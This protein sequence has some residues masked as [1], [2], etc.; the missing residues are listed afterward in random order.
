MSGVYALAFNPVL[1]RLYTGDADLNTISYY[2]EGLTLEKTFDLTTLIHRNRDAIAPSHISIDRNNNL[3]IAMF[4]SHV[5]VKFDEELNYIELAYPED[6]SDED[7]LSESTFISPPIV[8]TDMNNDIWVCYSND[9]N[10]ML[11]KFNSSGKELFK[12]S[13]NPIDGLPS[14][15]VPVSLAIDATNG[16]W[17]AC[18]HEN[19]IRNYSSSG[20]LLTA[21]P[22]ISP[23]YIVIDRFN[24]VWVTHEYDL[25]SVYNTTSSLVSTWKFDFVNEKVIKNIRNTSDLTQ[26]PNQDELWGGLG[27]DVFDNMWIIDSVNNK[28]AKFDPQNPLS[29]QYFNV[30]PTVDVNRVLN[31]NGSEITVPSRNS[32][33][34]QAGGDWTG[35]R[36]Y[37]KYSGTY[38]AIN[39]S[40]TSAPF[41][42]QDL[43]KADQISKINE[44]F[45]F[46]EHYK[47]LALPEQ[48]KNNTNL[49]DNA[50]VGLVGDGD[51]SKESV[52]RIVYEKIA[53]FISAHGDIDTMDSDK[54]ISIAESMAV[55]TKNFG[56]DF[57]VAVKR[58]VDLFSIPKQ[59][60]RGIP[61]IVDFTDRI[62]TRIFESDFITANTYYVAQDRTFNSYQLIYTS[63]LSGN[64]LYYHLSDIQAEGLRTPILNN[65]YFYEYNDIK[66]DGYTGN[67]IDWNSAQTT[68]S[69]NLSSYEDWY[70]DG[71][72]V[73]TAFNNLLTKQLYLQ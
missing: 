50:F 42:V 5:V 47:G 55:D 54:L 52:G 2:S 72:L 11:I 19:A 22:F 62:G 63:P 18:K 57:P 70:G 24:N 58:L 6:V 66:A 40:G 25:C 51:I 65:Y 33:S 9:K 64:I 30:Q 28:Y 31:I 45:N 13:N 67:L 56:E 26:N 14:T 53:N 71:G 23:S 39:I 36:W 73:E 34:A 41:K 46:A 21:I 10:S 27:T 3:W 8:E 59:N 1:N 69:Y 4:D 29:I 61:N 68:I 20:V 60:L 48:L 38:D 17:V 35:N 12:V 15:S 16:V 44:D 49:F 37:Q 32:K 7:L 43:D